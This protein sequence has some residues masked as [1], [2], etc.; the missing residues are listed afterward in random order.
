MCQDVLQ[1]FFLN[2][3]DYLLSLFSLK[4][5]LITLYRQHMRCEHP[6]TCTFRNH[7]EWVDKKWDHLG[8]N[9]SDWLLY[10]GSQ[11]HYDPYK[12]NEIDIHII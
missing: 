5:D 10:S 11:N 1:P 9:I 4:K 6:T 7:N 2:Y 8:T 12:I 3:L